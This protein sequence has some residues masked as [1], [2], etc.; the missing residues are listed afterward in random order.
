[1]GMMYHKEEKLVVID[2]GYFYAGLIAEVGG[3]VLCSAPILKYMIGWDSR[4]VKDYCDIKKW[5]II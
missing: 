4:K 5:K 2:S 3:L 1:M